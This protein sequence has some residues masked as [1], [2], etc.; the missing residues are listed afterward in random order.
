MKKKLLEEYSFVYFGNIFSCL[1]H[2]MTFIFRILS[3]C[4][5]HSLQMFVYVYLQNVNTCPK[6]S[7]PSIIN[8]NWVKIAKLSVFLIDETNLTNLVL[9]FF[10]LMI[11]FF[12][13]ICSSVKYSCFFS[14][15]MFQHVFKNEPAFYFHRRAN[16]HE[17]M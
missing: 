6:T 4:Y 8:Q 2:P 10:L 5:T 11:F 7:N 3:V 1:S 14:N 17:K 13:N 16:L 9:F 12:L 15:T